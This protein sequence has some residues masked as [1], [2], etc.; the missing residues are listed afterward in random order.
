MSRELLIV[1]HAKSAWDTDAPTDFERPLAKRG[2][3]DAPR[4]GGWL[5]EQGLIPEQVV[6]SPAK[7]AKQ[8]ANRLCRELG[9]KRTR[10]TW[11]PRI[12]GGG[13][14][15]LLAVLADC[16]KTAQRVMLVGHNPGLEDLVSHLAG[17]YLAVPEDGKILPTAAVAHFDMPNDW[18]QLEAGAGHLRSITRPRS[19]SS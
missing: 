19:L 15:T 8:T 17:G 6:S 16:D 14:H 1:R 11:D 12:Y 5:V 13:T 3:L 10:V 18:C 9:I 7:R 4:I 2:K